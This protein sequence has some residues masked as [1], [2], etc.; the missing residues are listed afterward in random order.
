[1]ISLARNAGVDVAAVLGGTPKNALEW[2]DA[3]EG[4]PKAV[5]WFMLW[6]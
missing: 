4:F 3:F 5:I 1:M 6:V 2:N